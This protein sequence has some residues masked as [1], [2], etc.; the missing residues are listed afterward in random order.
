MSADS[1]WTGSVLFRVGAVGLLAAVGLMIPVL[2]GLSPAAAAPI[3]PF[4]SAEAFVAQQYRDFYEREADAN[5]SRYWT[6]RLAGGQAAPPQVIESFMRSPEFSSSRAPVLRL[7]R[8]LFGRIPDR[9]GFRYWTVRLRSG[10]VPATIANFFAGS[11]E[12][13]NRYGRLDDRA[14]VVELY[15][16]VLGRGADP[17]GL[18]F[19]VVRLRSGSTR[20]DLVSLLAESREY[21]T[22]SQVEIEVSMVYLGMFQRLPDPAEFKRWTLRVGG[23][24][25]IRVMIDQVLSST[26]YAG[27]FS[28][29]P[30]AGP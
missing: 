27:R 13:V 1:R 11:S 15:Q 21:R 14:F 2:P 7:Y 12:F 3:G 18:D 26:E 20:G 16:Q 8:A 30:T 4:G 22:R 28:P 6:D 10:A 24:E 17:A 19:W 23:G 9:G 29:P 25:S 5:G